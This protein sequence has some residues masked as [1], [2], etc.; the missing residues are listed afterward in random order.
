M[1][2]PTAGGGVGAVEWPR[3]ARRLEAAGH[4][5]DV[6]LTQQPGDGTRLARAALA[7]GAATLVAVGGDG[8]FH[9]VAQGFFDDAGEPRAPEAC[10][11]L[12]P[13]GTGNDF[14][15]SLGGSDTE[16][17]LSALAAGRSRRIDVLGVRFR[18]RRGAPAFRVCLNVLSVGAAALAAERAHAWPAWLRGLRYLAGGLQT[19]GDVRPFRLRWTVDGLPRP[20]VRALLLVVGN[21]GFFGAGMPILPTARLEDGRAQL[22]LVREAPLWQLL[23]HAPGLCLGTHLTAP[24]AEHGAFQELTAEVDAPVDIDGEPVGGGPLEVRVLPGALRL[25]A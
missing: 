15:R 21:G 6:R 25:L 8:T 2:N 23:A 5:V 19:L 3:V 18:T 24:F 1:A 13:A 7:S 22:L 4:A 10:L 11:G 14:V 12:V 17:V 20:D 9:E 16:R